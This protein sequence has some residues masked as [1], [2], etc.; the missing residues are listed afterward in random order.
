M[1]TCGTCL[2]YRYEEDVNPISGATTEHNFCALDPGRL[3]GYH[4]IG[5]EAYDPDEEY[6]KFIGFEETEEDSRNLQTV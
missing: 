5:C 3:C 6:I 1:K 2:N 4:C